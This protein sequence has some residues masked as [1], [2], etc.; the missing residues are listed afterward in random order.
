MVLNDLVDSFCYSQKNAGL[1]GLTRVAL[2]RFEGGCRSERRLVTNR[3]CA[4]DIVL[5][6]S[7]KRELQEQHTR[8]CGRRLSKT[9]TA[10]LKDVQITREDDARLATVQKLYSTVLE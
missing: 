8:S 7:A 3:R 9:V 5:I 6:A 10:D 4:N 1:K 2:D